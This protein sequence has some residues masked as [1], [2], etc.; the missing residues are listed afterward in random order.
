LAA[1]AVPKLAPQ[2]V[3][4]LAAGATGGGA[5]TGDAVLAGATT[6]RGASQTS[7]SV[8]EAFDCKKHELQVHVAPDVEGLAIAPHPVNPVD[9]VL[10]AAA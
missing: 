1:G 10:V 3:K 5:W 4:P 2:P 6:G 9:G 7:H 8:L